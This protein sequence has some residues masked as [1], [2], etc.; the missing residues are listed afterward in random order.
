MSATNTEDPKPYKTETIY[1]I[2]V[3]KIVR[4]FPFRNRDYQKI[5]EDDQG[6]AEYAYVYF[7]DSKDVELDVYEQTVEYI[8]MAE[9]IKAVNGMEA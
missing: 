7:D 1:R 2:R 4:N 6:E 3:T 8:D 5:S 9:V